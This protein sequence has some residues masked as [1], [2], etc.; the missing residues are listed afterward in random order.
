MLN[1]TI[2]NARSFETAVRSVARFADTRRDNR[3][4]STEKIMVS[5]LPNGLRLTATD[6]YTAVEYAINSSEV[7]DMGEFCIKAKHLMALVSLL[8]D[9]S[10]FTLEQTETGLNLSLKDTP[11][12]QARFD[13]SP[14]DEF[15][16]LPEPDP[17][18]HW[19]ELDAAH[20]KIIK[21]LT[22]YAS[23]DKYRVGYDA[24]QFAMHDDTLFAYTTD[25]TTVATAELGTSAK[26]PNFA[27]PIEGIKKALQVNATPALKNSG[28]RI[29]LPTDDSN[30]VS[31]QIQDTAVKVK[32]GDS[33]DLTAWILKH[34]SYNG[35]AD[36]HIV[37]QPKAL[38]DGL[39][40]VSKL[41]VKEARFENVLIIESKDGKMTMT[42][43]PV[44]KSAY[45]TLPQDA[46]DMEAEYLH[47]F[48]FPEAECL[49]G[50]NSFRILVD[51]P[52][53]QNMVK[54]IAAL[55]PN[56]ISVQMKYAVKDNE[57]APTTDTIAISGSGVPL[58]VLTM[59]TK[60]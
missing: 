39:K 53:F 51:A 54:D 2:G 23:T 42:A 13:V 26:I 47:E 46:A 56:A 49:T 40:K 35:D 21:A 1:V 33:V 15:P 5:T 45:S 9:Q 41:F 16:M 31:I 50:V 10:A 19:I 32:S 27:I 52:K 58:G 29:T 11:M 18:A 3:L 30:V 24:L 25:G 12:F 17:K 38:T 34:E 7:L 60:L 28:W 44:K 55:K 4:E 20:V 57:D 6:L 59:P 8:K 36:A 22:K 43:K 48:T 14:T 37:F